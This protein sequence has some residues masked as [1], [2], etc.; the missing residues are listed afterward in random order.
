MVNG[1]PLGLVWPLPSYVQPGSPTFGNYN[2]SGD[3]ASCPI[4]GALCRRIGSS[5]FDWKG[6]CGHQFHLPVPGSPGQVVFLSNYATTAS[7][8]VGIE[9]GHVRDP[10]SF[11]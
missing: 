1:N 7:A 11:T 2:L 10:R 4:D 8:V 9:A 3:R 5:V 6:D